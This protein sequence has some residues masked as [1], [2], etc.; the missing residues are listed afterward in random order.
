MELDE[1]KSAW[2]ALDRRLE[3]HNAIHLQLL[4]DSKVRKIRASL[5][6]LFW[7]Q[8]AQILFGIPFILLGVAVWTENRDVLPLL[9][10]GLAVH[11]YGVASVACG[12]GTLGLLS[13]IDD[14]LPVLQ[15]QKRL[16]KLRRFYFVGNLTLGMSWWVFP[17]P[18]AMA[19][20]GLFGVDLYAAAPT[21]IWTALICSSAGLA[22]TWAALWGLRR[23]ALRTGRMSVLTRCDESAAGESIRKAQRNIDEILRFEQE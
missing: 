9:L 5:R 7:G 6:P 16:A 13:R 22:L 19:I 15:I 18:L 10:A 23:W 17:I 8:I 4:K 12:G 2:Q 1:L 11:I 21:A 3:Q 20:F 14:S